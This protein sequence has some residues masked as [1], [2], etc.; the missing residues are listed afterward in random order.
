MIKKIHSI[1]PIGDETIK[2]VE[3]NTGCR[4]VYVPRDEFLNS[5]ILTD[6]EALVCRDRDDIN[7]IIDACPSLSFMF[8]V[9]V[10]V[11]RLPFERLAERGI[12]VCNPRGL[13]SPIMA[14]Y[15]LGAILAHSTRIWEN[16]KNQFQSHWKKFQCVEPLNGKKLLVIGAGST[17]SL[18]AQKAKMFGMKT[19]GIKRRK[20]IV[21]EFDEIGT[22]DDLEDVLPD[23]DFV[24]CTI[25][26][27]PS[28]ERLFTERRFRMMK[29]SALFV[30]I[31]RGKIISENDLVKCLES[32]TPGAAVLDVFEKEPLTPESPLWKTNNLYVTPHSSGRLQNFVDKT[33]AYLIESVNA[34][35]SGK[36]VPN[37]VDLIYGY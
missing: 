29:T 33:M 28:T 3:E 6:V 1:E 34:V 10:G 17:G 8:I 9:S 2:I 20:T 35:N 15:V 24:V 37:K 4:F 5:G 25:P 22:L 26:L 16:L 27:T 12:T 18:I 11:E 21:P 13:N 19:I 7:A 23:A 32:G 36:D 14:E 30:N 31:S